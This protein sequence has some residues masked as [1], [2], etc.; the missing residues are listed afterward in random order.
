MAALVLL[1][2]A[3]PALRSVLHE[4]EASAALQRG[5]A[6]AVAKAGQP[7]HAVHIEHMV[8]ERVA[9]VGDVRVYRLEPGLR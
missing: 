7:D 5:L 4:R 3:G 2:V 6:L 9:V 1:A 8:A